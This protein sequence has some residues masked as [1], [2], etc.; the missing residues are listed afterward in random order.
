MSASSA[1]L[2]ES[3]LMELVSARPRALLL[4]RQLSDEELAVFS[5][6]GRRREVA[7]REVIFRAEL[8]RT[9][10]GKMVKGRLRD[11]Y[12]GAV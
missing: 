8:P 4:P 6:A 5:S 12:E 7:P 3:D 1:S 11:A 9:P 2:S 10:T